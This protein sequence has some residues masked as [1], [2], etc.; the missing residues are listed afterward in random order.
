MRSRKSVSSWSG[1]TTDND[2]FQLHCSLKELADGIEYT[3]S[4]TPTYGGM[5]SA[6]VGLINKTD[7]DAYH[8][9]KLRRSL[10]EWAYKG[11]YVLFPQIVIISGANAEVH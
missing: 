6:L 2:T 7:R 8:G 4:A 5:H 10:K 11:R 9:P 3:F 1:T